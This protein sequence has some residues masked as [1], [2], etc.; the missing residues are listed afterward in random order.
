MTTKTA[1]LLYCFMLNRA[2]P[3][4]HILYILLRIYDNMKLFRYEIDV[5]VNV[6]RPSLQV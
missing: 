6:P 4:A 1:I 3:Y 2:L 5:H